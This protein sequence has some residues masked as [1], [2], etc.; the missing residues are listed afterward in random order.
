[1]SAFL[2][3]SFGGF[4]LI[5][6]SQLM[7]AARV[8]RDRA[9]GIPLSDGQIRL[10]RAKTRAVA[11]ISNT[12]TLQPPE[13]SYPLLTLDGEPYIRARVLVRYLTQNGNAYTFHFPEMEPKTVICAAHYRPEVRLFELD[14]EVYVKLSLL[15]EVGLQITLAEQGLLIE[16]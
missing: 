15:R 9:L 12:L 4:V 2:Y 11:V 5:A 3:G 7:D 14:D 1:M 13:P 8:M 6:L 10:I 16:T